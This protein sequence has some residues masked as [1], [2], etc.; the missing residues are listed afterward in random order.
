MLSVILAFVIPDVLFRPDSTAKTPIWVSATRAI[1][2]HGDLHPALFDEN[3]IRR[4]NDAAALNE[5]MKAAETAEPVA[6]CHVFTGGKVADHHRP[7]Q[8]LDDLV[9][10]A[11]AILH[12]K[13]ARS[14]EGFLFGQPGSLLL[15]EDVTWLRSFDPVLAE[16]PLL[17][18]YPRATILTRHGFLCAKPLGNVTAPEDGDRL[19]LFPMV[20]AVRTEAGNLVLTE[21]HREIVIA[22]PEMIRAVAAKMVRE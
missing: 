4:L 9:A 8:S 10:H 17:V 3:V 20:D 15:L 13:V 22:D 7:N 1:T 6:D 11:E 19:L 12:G 2:K 14:E 16:G 21:A 5:R 18:F